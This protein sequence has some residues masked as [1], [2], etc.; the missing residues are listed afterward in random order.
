MK[1]MAEQADDKVQRDPKANKKKELDDSETRKPS[2]QNNAEGK[3]EVNKKAQQVNMPEIKVEEED[4]STLLTPK[5]EPLDFE[6][7]RLPR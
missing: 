2:V 3:N 1:L 4:S 7:V 6:K 5:L